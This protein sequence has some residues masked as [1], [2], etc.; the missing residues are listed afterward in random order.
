MGAGAAGRIL[1]VLAV[2]ARHEVGARA[3]PRQ[4]LAPGQS[5]MAARAQVE[6]ARLVALQQRP[7]VDAKQLFGRNATCIYLFKK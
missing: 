5:E 1:A 7:V 3:N 4:V 6:A 2:A